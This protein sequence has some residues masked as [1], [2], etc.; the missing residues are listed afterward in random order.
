MMRS[1]DSHTTCNIE[2]KTNKAQANKMYIIYLQ[3]NFAIVHF[4]AELSML[5]LDHLSFKTIDCKVKV[6]PM[7]FK[8]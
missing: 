7:Q 4:F 6:I 8:H 1:C 3:C 5:D 2:I